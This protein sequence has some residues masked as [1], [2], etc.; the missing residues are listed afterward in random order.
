MS[1]SKKLTFIKTFTHVHH[2]LD[3]LFLEHQVLL[4]RNDFDNALKVVNELC[5]KYEQHI[6]DEESVLIPAYQNFVKPIPQGGAVNFFLREH[7]QIMHILSEAKTEI[8]NWVNESKFTPTKMVSLFDRY[9]SLRD[10]LNHHHAREDTFLYRLLDRNTEH[11]IQQKIIEKI[12]LLPQ[13][14]GK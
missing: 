2:C 4:M 10:L 14:A 11:S 13:K 12:V 5:L 6:L 7:T 8:K 9:Y 1:P 3:N